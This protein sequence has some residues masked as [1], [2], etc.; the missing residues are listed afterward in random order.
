[1]EEPSLSGPQL[2]FCKARASEEASGIARASI[3][4]A[5]NR[6]GSRKGTGGSGQTQQHTMSLHPGVASLPWMKAW[7]LLESE[8]GFGVGGGSSYPTGRNS[9]LHSGLC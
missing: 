2:P 8:T 4:N 5:E 7:G 1:M 3:L 9:C 6:A